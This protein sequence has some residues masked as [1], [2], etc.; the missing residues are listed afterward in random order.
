M[1]TAVRTHR[2]TALAVTFG[3]LLAGLTLGAPAQP[4]EAATNATNAASVLKR[5]N[6]N[7]VSF[8]MPALKS[9]A[10]ITQFAQAWAQKKANA[11]STA[12]VAAPAGNLPYDYVYDY[13][14]GA[15]SRQSAERID[16]RFPQ[17]N[18]S[19][20]DINV[21]Q[22][23]DEGFNYGAVG[24]VKKGNRNY[25]V[26]VLMTYPVCAESNLVSA[27]AAILGTGGVGS[28]LTA[29][30]GT[31]SRNTLFLYDWSVDGV[32][33]GWEKTF[34]PTPEQKAMTVTLEVT[35]YQYCFA[36]A[37]RS[38]SKKITAGTLTKRTPVVSGDRNVGETLTVD[39]GA[40]LPVDTTHS[41]QWLRNGVAIADA[42]SASYEL[43]SLDRGKRIDVRVTGSATGYT[44]SAIVTATKTVVDYPLLDDMPTPLITGD[45]TFGQ[46]L[47]ADAGV[48]GPSPVT[49]TY[50]WRVSGVLVAKATAPTFSVPASAVGKAVTVTV[51][52]S[53]PG[54]AT[55]ARSSASTTPVAS[56]PFATAPVPTVTGVAKRGAKL[57]AIVAGWPAGTVISYQWL[58]NDVVIKKSVSRTLVPATGFRTGGLITVRVTASKPGFTT[59]VVTS[60]P[61]V[62]G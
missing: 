13:I 42:T 58:L 33:V 6:A 46:V 7:R 18:L 11:T 19:G 31:W 24:F 37:S 60:A 57:T 1:N 2:M 25:A 62:F 8:G 52:G 29:S 43:Q 15:V 17:A 41:F 44:T 35:G 50:Q 3:L 45:A 10:A 23:G 26:L 30:V 27:P 59:T 28:T 5:V 48:W 40:W 34:V 20:F 22:Y 12:K 39:P 53:S 16:P 14:P 38:T 32:Q 49:L 55:K 47:T 54:F 4:A 56:L 36:D 21:T 9:N 51:T 61:V